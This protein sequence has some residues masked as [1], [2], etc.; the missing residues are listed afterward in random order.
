MKWVR[1][2]GSRFFAAAGLAAVA[3]L[4]A[5]GMAQA[6]R[7]NIVVIQTD[8][9]SARSVKATFREAS[10]KQVRVMPNTVKNIFQGGTQFR[11]YY[12]T[13]PVCSP[14]RASLL[15]GQYAQ[16]HGL[17]Q[18]DP[19]L[20]GWAGWKNLATYSQNLPVALQQAGYRTSHFGKIMNGYYDT[21]SDRVETVVPPGWDRWFSTSFTKGALFYGY[22]VNDDGVARRGFGN[23]LYSLQTGLDPKRCDVKT[24][25]RQRFAG[26]CRHLTDTMTRAAV[27]EIRQNSGD[28]LFMQIDYQAPHGDIRPPAGPMPATRHLGSTGRT[29]LPRPANFNE[30]DMSDKSQVI[31]DAAPARLGYWKNQGLK[32]SYQRYIASLRAVDDGVGAIIR[33]LLAAGELDNTYIFFLSDHGFFFGEHRFSS[34]KFL[35]YDASAKVSMAVRGPKVPAGGRSNE[36]VGNVD[37]APTVLRAAGVDA[38][39]E[40]D[41]RPLNRFWRDPVLTSRR[42]LGLA[43]SRTNG[44]QGRGGASVSNRAPALTYD[45]FMVGPYKYFRF[46][47]SDEAELYDL[48]RDPSE[49]RN[50]IDSPAYAQVRQ[51]ME[52]WVAQ[53]GGCSGADCRSWLPQWPEPAASG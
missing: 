28:P 40:M 25:T 22:E 6:A 5:P 3:V 9:Q 2:H 39:Y 41:G 49:M 1:R 8:D 18:N 52:F 46:Q 29:P 53:V 31:Q 12:A 50:V 20:G 7:P 15:T 47:S 24:L 26:G 44:E 30:A 37:V 11:N 16:N 45:G 17:T 13:S 4:T 35:P 33:T 38:G 32:R 34:A 27:R 48:R 14:S 10:G 23:S 42:P 36:L 43:Y 19:P 51:Y 21:D